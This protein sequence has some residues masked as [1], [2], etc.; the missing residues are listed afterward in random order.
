MKVMRPSSAAPRVSARGNDLA[1]ADVRPHA[2]TGAILL[3][4]GAL[5]FPFL[6]RGPAT[7][8][9]GGATL[10]LECVLLWYLP[11]FA[12][13][14]LVGPWWLPLAGVV[15]FPAAAAFALVDPAVS[16]VLA[17][18]GLAHLALLALASAARGAPWRGGV[19]FWSAGPH[20]EGDGA[21]A[22][23]MAGGL[24]L[25][26]AAAFDAR[27][28][29][30][31]LAL[32]AAGA[33]AHLVP[34]ARGRAPLAPAAYAG[35]GMV[36]MAALLTW[37][38]PVPHAVTAAGL[39]LLAGGIAGG[40]AGKKAGP[41]L[42]D[43]AAPLVAA[44]APLPLALLGV[45]GTLAASAGLALFALLLLALPVVF[46]QRPASAFIL[47]AAALGAL[48]PAAAL[49]PFSWGRAVASLAVLLALAALAPLRRPRR[50]C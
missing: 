9:L 13:R 22:V 17:G 2:W 10:L 35:A 26:L 20:R 16:R 45:P 32:V 27:A 29:I 36:F 21:A 44:L 3:A 39:L 30:P 33:L 12:K 18:I 50:E 48:A 19:P 7:A 47:P 41:R 4:A 6:A 49:L 23:A 24:V 31:G 11:S 28:W 34:R 37:A 15:A 14:R 40:R 8:L 38:R 1:T 5:A 46:N 25:L 42:R 43:A